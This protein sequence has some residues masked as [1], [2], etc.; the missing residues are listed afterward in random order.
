MPSAASGAIFSIVNTVY[1]PSAPKGNP[2]VDRGTVVVHPIHESE[3]G[4][5]TLKLPFGTA[6][7]SVGYNQNRVFQME[8]K[9]K[10][11]ARLRAKLAAKKN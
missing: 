2:R 8:R 11:V 10:A 5:L 1:D 9:T 3:D 4:S 6:P 7:D